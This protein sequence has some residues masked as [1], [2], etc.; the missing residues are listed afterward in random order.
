MDERHPCHQFYWSKPGFFA[1]NERKVGRL[2]LSSRI[3]ILSVEKLSEGVKANQLLQGL[4]FFFFS[5]TRGR[6]FMWH[7]STTLFSAVHMVSQQNNCRQC[8]STLGGAWES[9][10]TFFTFNLKASTVEQISRL[11]KYCL[12]VYKVQFQKIGTNKSIISVAEQEQTS[13]LLTLNQ[14]KTQLLRFSLQPVLFHSS[15]EF[16]LEKNGTVMKSQ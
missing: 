5:F 7:R 13:Y 12:D 14:E 9:T 11:P 3:L 8:F 4:I 16:P 15:I 2:Q 1:S 10:I 6:M